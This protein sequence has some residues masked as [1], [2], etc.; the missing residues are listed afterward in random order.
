MAKASLTLDDIHDSIHAHDMRLENLES[1]RSHQLPLFGHF[2]CRLAAQPDCVSRE[3]CSGELTVLNVEAEGKKPQ[4]T[5]VW[6]QLQAFKMDM[7][8]CRAHWEQGQDAMRTV[9]VDRV[10]WILDKRWERS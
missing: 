3:C 1:R 4:W 2:C 5:A 8:A 7:W 6:A 10:C 9:A